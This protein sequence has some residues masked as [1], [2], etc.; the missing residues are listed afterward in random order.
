MVGRTTVV[1]AHRLSTIRNVGLN[2]VIQQGQVV[3]TGTH[4][5]LISRAGA[6]AVLDPVSKR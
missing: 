2:A 4:E 3:E 1:V 6:Y 5:E